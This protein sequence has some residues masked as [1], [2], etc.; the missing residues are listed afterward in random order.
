M[1]VETMTLNE[2]RNVTLTAYLQSVQGEFDYIV[3]RPAIL[4]LPGGGYQY[5]SDREAD[6]VAMAYLKAGYQVF[7]LR[8]SVKQ[9][10]TWPN[11]INDYEQAMECIRSKADEWNLYEDKVAVLGFSAG[12]HLAGCAATMAKQKPNAAI[13]GYAVTKKETIAQ[14]EPTAPDVVSAVDE[15]TCPCFVFATRNDQV[16]PVDNSIELMAALAKHGISFE[17]HIY[18][19]GPHGFSTADCSIQYKESVICDRAPHWVEDSIA[20]LRDM[21][22]EF[23]MKCMT[24]PVCGS[25]VTSDYDPYLS[26]DCT[27]GYLRVCESAKPVMESFLPWLLEHKEMVAKNIGPAAYEF[28][29][30]NG[31]EGAYFMMDTRTLREILHN[32][33]YTEEQIEQ[34]N[35]QLNQLKNDR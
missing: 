21:F 31:V 8:Y 24:K 11:P 16:V 18:A 17:S 28:V 30:K 13:L 1:R 9:Y 6:P 12:G 22:G 27:F 14:C 25:H 5:C 20:W 34:M 7:I 15:R 26:V 29:T 32:A 35:H 3:K 23:G 19:Y 2:E 33:K 10:A 4:I